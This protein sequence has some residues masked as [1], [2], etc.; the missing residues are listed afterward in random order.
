MDGTCNNLE[1]SSRG[2]TMSA[3]AKYLPADFADGIHSEL[4][5]PRVLLISIEFLIIH[6][7]E[8]APNFGHGEAF[9]FAPCRLGHGS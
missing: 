8:R 2:S 1:V 6:R 5:D 7:F 4:N 3:L 9:T